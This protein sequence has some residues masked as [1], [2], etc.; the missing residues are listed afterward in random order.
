MHFVVKALKIYF[1][2]LFP[3]LSGSYLFSQV[4]AY[5]DEVE[6]KISHDLVAQFK[7]EDVETF[8]IDLDDAKKMHHSQYDFELELNIQ[9]YKKEL[10][11]RYLLKLKLTNH[12]DNNS[13]HLKRLRARSP[14]IT[15]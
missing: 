2:I 9:D 3:L 8:V 15:S 4:G 7:N 6:I 5:E 12:S 14:P 1:L 10:I 13:N 11:S